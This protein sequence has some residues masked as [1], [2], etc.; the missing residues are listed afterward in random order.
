MIRLHDA[1]RLRRHWLHSSGGLI[2]HLRALRYR[3]KLW[4]GFGH[5]VGDWLAAWQPP[6]D[7]LLIVG[8]SAGYTLNR[9]FLQRWQEVAVLE[10]DPL[11]RWLLRRRHPDVTWYFDNLDLLRDDRGL[12]LPETRYAQHAILFANVLGQVAPRS[13]AESSAWQQSLREK[14]VSHHWASY[15]DVISTARTPDSACVQWSIDHAVTL[16]EV[17]SHFWHGGEL[18]LVDHCTLG[19][20]GR[21]NAGTAYCIWPLRPGQYHLVEWLTARR[22]HLATSGKARTMIKA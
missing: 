8:P 5:I 15:H 14:L 3:K 6:T 10:P 16:G 18:E 20:G 7:K 17:L 12:G 19:L 1:P 2:W 11:A 9:H 22:S 4:Q 13:A 21:E